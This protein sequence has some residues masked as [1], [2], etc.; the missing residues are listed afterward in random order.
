MPPVQWWSKKNLT[1]LDGVQ[2]ARVT[3]KPPE[4][5]VVYDPSK[6]SIEDLI[7]ATT[8]AGYPSS[9]KKKGGTMRSSPRVGVKNWQRK[10]IGT[11]GSIVTSPCCF[12]GNERRKP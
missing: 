11:I 3:L 8:N 10:K 12:I 6:I 2:E 4:A 7:K 9:V 1:K 5:V